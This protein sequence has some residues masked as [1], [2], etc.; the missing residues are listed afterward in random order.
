[1]PTVIVFLSDRW[2]QTAQIPPNLPMQTKQCDLL[3]KSQSQHRKKAG[4]FHAPV[5]RWESQKP[6]TAFSPCP[7][8]QSDCQ[9]GKYFLGLPWKNSEVQIFCL[10]RSHFPDRQPKPCDLLE[11][12]WKRVLRVLP[13][14]CSEP[15]LYPDRIRY[16]CLFHHEQTETRQNHPI[17]AEPG[18]CCSHPN[19]RKN[20]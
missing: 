8:K 4:F 6:S 13:K 2:K 11:G 12:R 10:S 18:R 14:D 15:F 1:M 3:P 9:K 17:I 5:F 20:Q 7:H 16:C 19:I